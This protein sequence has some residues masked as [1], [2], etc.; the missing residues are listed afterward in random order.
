MKIEQIYTGCLAQGTY[1]IVSNGE[2]PIID[3]LHDTQ[4]YLAISILQKDGFESLTEIKGGFN[5]IVNFQFSKS[6]LIAFAE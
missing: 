3:P 6:F 5:A 4:P 2:A 1:Y